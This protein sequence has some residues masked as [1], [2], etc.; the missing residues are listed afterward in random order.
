M[1]R[2]PSSIYN[3]KKHQ[4]ENLNPLPTKQ[5]MS[6]K[7]SFKVLN[8]V[9]LR[10][11]PHRLPKK[12]LPFMTPDF[13]R[14][15]SEA[16]DGSFVWFGHSSFMMKLDSRILLFDPAYFSLSPVQGIMNRFSP[17]PLDLET[18]PEIDYLIL[19]HN[20]YDHLDLKALKSLV[21]K[22][23]KVLTP[24]KVQQYL[25]SFKEF[26]PEV[27][28]LDWG[29]EYNDQGLK[30]ICAPA[31][32][33][34]GRGLLDRNTTLWCSWVIQSQSQKIY[35]SGD[36]GYSDHFKMIG[37]L[38]GPF[39]LT[40]LENGQ[41]NELWK[42]VHMLP[43][44]AIQAHLDLKGNFLVPIHWGSYCL[45]VHSWF[46]P[47]ERALQAS[48]KSNVSILFPIQGQIV[49]D[50]LSLLQQTPWWKNCLDD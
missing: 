24:L 25:Q 19:S 44:E 2:L 50:P 49:T 8:E 37:D 22:S 5:M 10:R 9:S 11:S 46:E 48:Q 33:F 42:A 1:T 6:L 26:L 14:F 4:F 43:E 34:S 3:P 38:Y 28:E 18:F 16:P 12:P 13:H 47:A 23:K 7:N 32:H 20:H 39:D 21:R 17:F 36:T 30:F 27:Q 15:K 35:F 31:Q 45:S 40:F 41:Y 29:Q